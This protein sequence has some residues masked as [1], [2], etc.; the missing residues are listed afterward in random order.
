MPQSR[1]SKKFN[2]YR[3]D[4]FHF[5]EWC[6]FNLHNILEK[7]DAADK[8]AFESGKIPQT[9]FDAVRSA[10]AEN[11]KSHLSSHEHLQV[12]KNVL[13]DSKDYDSWMN[14]PMSEL[15]KLPKRIQ[16]AVANGDKKRAKEIHDSFFSD[17]GETRLN[18]YL[19]VWQS[20]VQARHKLIMQVTNTKLDDKGHLDAEQYFLDLVTS[21][22]TAFL[23]SL[24][25]FLGGVEGI[26]LKNK[27]DITYDET[28]MPNVVLLPK[29]SGLWAS[30]ERL[31]TFLKK[32]GRVLTS[33]KKH[34]KSLHEP[35]WLHGVDQTIRFVTEGW[36]E[37]IV[38][39]EERW[40]ML[41]FLTTSCLVKFLRLCKVKHCKLGTKDARTIEREIQRLGLVRIP[42]GRVKH[43]ERRGGKFYFS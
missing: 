24:R 15:D 21:R 19:R 31:N 9:V 3:A 22:G 13:P 2:S 7:L 26:T 32:L 35:D 43:V 6:R 28:L 40:P 39:D 42:K 4:A 1:Y 33:K 36:C 38:V 16:T 34:G 37:N 20:R 27:H 8:R 25:Y 17:D 23:G 18:D 12:V 41:C 30:E 11:L 14:C 29:K 5:F 10:W